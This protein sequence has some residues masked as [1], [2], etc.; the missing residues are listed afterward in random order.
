MENFH[1]KRF[2]GESGGYRKARNAL[3]AAEIE[4][5]KKIEEVAATRRGLPAGGALAEDYVF[6]EGGA[7]LADRDTVSQV[8][9]SELFEQGKDSLIVY[10]FMY[11]ADWEQ[12]CPMCT[13]ILDSFNGS[14]PH[15]RE[16]ANIVV[17]AKAPIQKIRSWARGRGWN[18]LRL[19]SSAKNTYNLDYLAET[20]D[21]EQFPDLNVFKKTAGGISHF[22]NAE[23]F[24][25]SPEEGQHPRHAD[26]FWPLWNLLD[27]TPEGRGTDWI[28][29]V[30]YS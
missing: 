17:V 20:P 25:V 6:E 5:R 22:Y 4:L 9:F 30:S 16:R 28:P 23:L 18:N 11:G 14:V 3:L 26:M 10:S 2:P 12:G 19:L 7:D 8:R 27:L 29:S 1:D 21:G 13:S 15:V 24:F